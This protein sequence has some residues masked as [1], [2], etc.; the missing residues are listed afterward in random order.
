MF[1]VKSLQRGGP[2]VAV[3]AKYTHRVTISFTA[4]QHAKLKRLADKRKVSLSEL[5][6]DLVDD[7]FKVGE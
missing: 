2:T 7:T 6:R 3:T 5:V 1:L 4:G